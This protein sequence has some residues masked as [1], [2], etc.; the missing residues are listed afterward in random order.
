MYANDHHNRTIIFTLAGI[1][2][3]VAYPPLLERFPDWTELG[4]ADPFFLLVGEITLVLVLF[5]EAA[6]ARLEAEGV[7]NGTWLPPSINR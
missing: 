5:S 6:H 3:F 7:F 4:V 1:L 2:I